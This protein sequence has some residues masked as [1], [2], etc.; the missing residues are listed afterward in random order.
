MADPRDIVIIGGG[1]MGL[2]LGYYLRRAGADF[3][4]LD[5][6][7]GPGGA[8]RHGWDSLRL[9][10]PAGYGSLPG[11]LMPP[12]AHEG[13]PTRDDVLDYLSRYEARYALPIQRPVRVTSVERGG[14]HLEVVADN[15]RFAARA[16]VSATGTW[17]H[18]HVP[19]IDGRETFTGVQVHSAHYDRPE[20]YSGQTVL[21]VGGG[22]SGA[23]IMAELAP[24]AHAL[25]VTTHDPLFRP[26]DVDG[27]VLFER[28]VARLKNGPSDTPMGGIGD[29]VMVPPV[30]DARARGDL[31]S[32]RP[33]ERMTARGV[34]WSD[35]AEMAVDAIIWCTG[36]RPALDHLAA[37]GVV[38]DSGQVLVESQRSIKE[39]RLLAGY[40]DWTGPGSATLMG[41]ARTA[42]GLVESL[43]A[44]LPDESVT[45]FD[46]KGADL[47]DMVEADDLD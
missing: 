20:D 40:G 39:P 17:S 32:V 8:W 41:A 11:W 2:S 25:W 45:A 28:A 37:L 26:D 19:D 30:K 22:N 16:V 18:P 3:L 12:P 9:F 31:Q 24:V 35:G 4:I 44:E 1:Q 27:R 7:E 5:A 42:R 14:D 21:V 29:I 34:I 13:Y 10:S 46:I 38:E 36:F 6:E 43:T 15:S 33:F 47:N 23:Q